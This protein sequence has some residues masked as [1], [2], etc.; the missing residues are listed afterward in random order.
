[1][2]VR[3]RTGTT[4]EE[5]HTE[6][7][8]RGQ[9]TPL[10]ERGGTVGGAL[11]VGE[12]D[13]FVLGRGTLRASVLQVRYVSAEGRI[14]NG[15]GPT[16]K[17]VTGFDL[18]RLMVG[19]LGTFGPPR[20]GDPANQPDPSGKPVARVHGRRSVR[21][22]RRTAAAEC[23]PV[24]RRDDVGPHRRARRRHRRRAFGPGA[25]RF[26]RRG[27]RTARTCRPRRWSLTPAELR[28]VGRPRTSVRSSP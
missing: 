26:V 15:G 16:V 21:R 25:A 10:V 17:N 12:N 4:V 24:G 3:V 13:I 22:V 5:L 1:M 23:R 14:V 19:A 9:R 11:A 7:A 28:T 18:P 6:L 8:A 2:T 27:E 20:R